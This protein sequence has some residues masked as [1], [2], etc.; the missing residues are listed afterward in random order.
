[1]PPFDISGYVFPIVSGT[2]QVNPEPPHDRTFMVDRFLGSG[3]WVDNQGHFLTCGHV[4]Q[5]LKPGQCPAI[6]QPFGEAKDR[7]I[8]VVESTIHPT[9]DM[10]VG[11]AKRFSPS[12]FLPPHP[13]DIIPGLDVTAFGFTEWG[14]SD[15]SLNID[16]RYLKGH[17]SRT[18]TEPSGLPTPY[19]VEVSFG[20]PSGFSGTPL[21]ADFKVVGML[22]GNVESKLQGYS[23]TEA[24]DGENLYRETAYRIYEYGLCHRISDLVEFLASCEIRP[25]E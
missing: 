16:V 9:L 15:G 13:I 12:Q 11:T 8:R 14:K 19:V 10:A 20:C 22:Y 2:P 24:R 18:S 4:L 25:F 5:E 1:M 17:V 6:G 21:L 7:Y 3:F 23:L